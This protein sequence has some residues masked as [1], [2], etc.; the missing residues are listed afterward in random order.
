MHNLKNNT[1]QNNMVIENE[2]LAIVKI[3]EA[4]TKLELKSK[5]YIVEN[6]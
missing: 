4:I 2:T 3:A 6:L 5:C 1:S